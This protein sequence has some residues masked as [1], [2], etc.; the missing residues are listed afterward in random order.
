M[1]EKWFKIVS[2]FMISVGKQC[3]KN[4]LRV[5]YSD[6]VVEATSSTM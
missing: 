6:A 2:N 1:K 5:E 4:V 3:F